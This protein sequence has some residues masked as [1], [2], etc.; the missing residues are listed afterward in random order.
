MKALIKNRKK[1][2]MKK[3][4]WSVVKALAAPGK[5]L[6]KAA[7]Q[8]ETKAAQEEQE[9]ENKKNQDREELIS[10]MRDFEKTMNDILNSLKEKNNEN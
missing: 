10:Q 2:K 9:R 7:A 4:F 5:N 6:W 1:L 8:Q 3:T